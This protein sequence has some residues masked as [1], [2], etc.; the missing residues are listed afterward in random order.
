MIPA[1]TISELNSIVKEK[2]NGQEAVIGIMMGRYNIQNIQQA[3][4]E[5]YQY[6]HL[7]SSKSFDIYWAGY[8]E[9]WGER[10]SNQIILN[11][12]KAANGVYFDLNAFVTFK[13]D[14]RKSK[15][16]TYSDTFQLVLCNVRDGIIKYDEHIIF[17]LEEN[18]NG[19]TAKLRDI[20]ENVI[21]L[22]QKESTVSDINRKIKSQSFWKV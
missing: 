14:F 15:I 2:Y 16:I 20:M 3:I 21:E 5:S 17:D 4:D 1:L 12:A 11:C 6:W 9:Y 7:N 22:C 13:N 19:S 18:L 10:T 8:G